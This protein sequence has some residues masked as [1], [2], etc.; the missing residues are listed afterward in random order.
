M[1]KKMVW[2]IA[3]CLVFIGSCVTVNIYFPAAAV[4]KAADVI[5]DDIQGK[6]PDQ[7]PD[8]AQKPDAPK[9]PQGSLLNE[10]IQ[11]LSFS[12]ATADAADVDIN[13]STPA[14]RALKDSLKE[15]FPQLKPF[16][17]KAAVGHTNNGYLAVRDVS[18]LSLKEKADLARLV[19]QQ[20]KDRR[21]LYEEIVRA[22]K[23]GADSVPKVEKA[24]ANSWRDKAQSGWWIQ[25]DAGA[26]V[27]K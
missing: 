1:R 5:V 24:F 27:K 25:N 17:E 19:D 2:A 15:R 23:L 7:K 21:A 3:I 6:V 22:N 14:I 4:Q 20:N 13:I 26:W 8:P 10:N 12:P 16:F 18:G 11:R 9:S